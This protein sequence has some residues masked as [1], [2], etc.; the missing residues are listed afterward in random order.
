LTTLKEPG[1]KE[2]TEASAL[3][4]FWP[5]WIVTVQ[6]SR[7]LSGICVTCRQTSKT[8]LW[9]IRKIFLYRITKHSYISW[10]KLWRITNMLRFGM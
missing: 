3:S 5:N 2:E 1:K 4:D 9:L 8:W 7:N 10:S 6:S